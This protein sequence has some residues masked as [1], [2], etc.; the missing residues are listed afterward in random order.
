MEYTFNGKGEFVLVQAN[1][2]KELLNI[3]GRFEQ[4]PDNI[5][6]EVRATQLTSVVGESPYQK[7]K[8]KVEIFFVA[9][10]NSSS[11]IEVK[12]RPSHAQWR[13]RLDVLAD[14]KRIYFD[15]PALKTQH[16]KGVTV[17]T[18]TH[19][20]DQS[21]VIIMFPSGAGVEIVEEK[22]FMATRVYL[23]WTFLVS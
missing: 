12:I 18:P 6:G 5:Y 1:K 19:V 22:G 17:Y 3:Q 9:Q 20:I 21:E 14:G 16:F 23:P 7:I 11:I 8:I 2:G 10:D 15:R 13:Y 4:V